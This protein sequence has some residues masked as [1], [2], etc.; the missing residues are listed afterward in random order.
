MEDLI[1]KQQA[2]IIEVEQSKD[3]QGEPV[4]SFKTEAEMDNQIFNLKSMSLIEQE[5]WYSKFNGFISQNEFMWDVVEELDN[6]RSMEDVTVIHNKYANLLLFNSNKVGDIDI[7]PYIPS[8][9][10]GSSM[11]CNK[12]GNVMIG[13][14]ICNFNDITSY[15]Q[16]EEIKKESLL[17]SKS[18]SRRSWWMSGTGEIKIR[19]YKY[20]IEAWHNNNTDWIELKLTSH[21]RITIFAWNKHRTSYFLKYFYCNN[22]SDHSLLSNNISCTTYDTHNTGNLNSGN[23]HNLVRGSGNFSLE[24]SIREVRQYTGRIAVSH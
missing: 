19:D 9:S 11:A 16:L 2:Q 7:A 17:L 20:W 4:L 24:G 22:W 6:I 12:N 3:E 1:I 23:F 18:N 10:L 15:S 13:G 21:R 14:K 5:Q 8:T